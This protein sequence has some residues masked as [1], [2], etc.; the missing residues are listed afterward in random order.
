MPMKAPSFA[1]VYDYLSEGRVEFLTKIPECLLADRVR[2]DTSERIHLN[3]APMPATRLLCP[4]PTLPE[5]TRARCQMK[6][7]NQIRT[8]T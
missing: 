2:E 3:C 4:P 5:A 1:D 7:D 8:P 6:I